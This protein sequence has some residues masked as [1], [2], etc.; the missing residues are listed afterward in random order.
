MGA[1]LPS[2]QASCAL[3]DVLAMAATAFPSQTRLPSAGEQTEVLKDLS[4]GTGD[5]SGIL[6]SGVLMLQPLGFSAGL[7]TFTQCDFIT[8]K[9]VV[10]RFFP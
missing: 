2:G 3:L 4:G 6:T 7:V 8:P 5:F 1:H 9:P 10:A